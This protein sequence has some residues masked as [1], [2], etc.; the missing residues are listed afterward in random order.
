[1]EATLAPIRWPD[2]IA[3]GCDIDRED[4]MLGYLAAHPLP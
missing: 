2:G 3:D 1:V 4:A